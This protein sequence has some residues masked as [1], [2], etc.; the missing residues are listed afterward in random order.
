MEKINKQESLL[1][2]ISN[3]NN[4]DEIQEYIKEVIKVRGFSEQRIQDSMLILIEETGELA[5]A[6][7]K[8]LPDFAS[9]L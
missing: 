5:K 9:R 3:K 4:I 1:S 6:I 7:R 2:S 8:T